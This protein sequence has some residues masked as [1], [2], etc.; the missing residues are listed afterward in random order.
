MTVMTSGMNLFP[1]LNGSSDMNTSHSDIQSNI[2]SK[3]SA[4]YINSN[5]DALAK[6]DPDINYMMYNNNNECKYYTIDKFRESIKSHT[7]L[8]MFHSNIRSSAAHMNDVICYIKNLNVNFSFIG[9]SETWATESSIN[10]MQGYNEHFCIRPHKRKG[11]GVSLYIEENIPFKIRKDLEFYKLTAK[12]LKKTTA[13]NVFETVFIE[14]DKSVFNSKRNIIVVVIYRAPNSSLLKFNEKL[15]E[16][17]NI[18]QKEKKYGYLM[19]D[20]NVDTKF[21]LSGTTLQTQQFTNHFLSHQFHKLITLATREY[22]LS[23]KLLDNIYTN[24][25]HNGQSGVFKWD[26]SDHYLIFT[27]REESAVLER[28]Q[29]REKRDYKMQNVSNFKKMLKNKNWFHMYDIPDIGTAFSYFMSYI[30]SIYNMNFPI[31][32]IKIKYNNR[33]EW[34][35]KTLKEEIVERESLLTHAKRFPTND[36]IEKYKIFKNTNLSRQRAAERNYYKEQL[37]LNETDLRKSWSIIKTIIGKE[38][39]LKRM[40]HID[41]I[42]DDR[43]IDDPVIIANHFNDYFI[44]VGSNL[45]KHINCSVNPLE[46]MS[47]SCNELFIPY[48]TKKEIQCTITT[49]KNSSAGVDELMPSVMK[50]CSED[51]IDPLAHLIN[52]SIQQGIFPSE[53]KLAKVIPIYK[54]NNLQLVQNYRTILVLPYFSKIFEKIISM[55]IFW[56]T[57]KKMTY[58]IVIS[59]DSGNIIPQVMP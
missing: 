25:P 7:K 36:N 3:D 37:E 48:I 2:M 49:L 32:K 38:D 1:Y 13:N 51:Y 59:M 6:I 39:K 22:N 31:K 47:S 30:I 34:I 46:Y 8:S 57:L 50:Q 9:F 43:L 45:A 55:S 24:D 17:L 44:H 53:L 42:I 20:Y 54:S 21:E 4:H 12:K 29:Y 26:T 10:V 33:N 18:I 40:K 23:S 27:I 41:F 52:L 16:L 28:E 14:I 19:G 11:G 5:N 58:C 15:E 56:I 35:T